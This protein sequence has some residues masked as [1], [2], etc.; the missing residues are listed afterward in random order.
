MTNP[1]AK[2]HSSGADLAKKIPRVHVD[3]FLLLSFPSYT[4]YQTVCVRWNVAVGGAMF[5]RS[6]T[7]SLLAGSLDCPVRPPPSSMAAT[8][9]QE[10]SSS[11]SAEFMA[12]A[13]PRGSSSP[14]PVE[15]N[16][17]RTTI[18]LPRV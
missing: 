8:L 15:M 7:M 14:A 5:R 18:P 10:S 1:T 3:S 17:H 12:A 9:P 2:A 11:T 16:G 4:L 13:L 6:P